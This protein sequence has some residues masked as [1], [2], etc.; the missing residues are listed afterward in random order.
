ME[1]REFGVRLTQYRKRVRLSTADLA[2]HAGVDYMQIARYEKG[3][4]APSLDSAIRLAIV[5][6]VSLDELVRGT[7]PP[8]PLVFKNQK[9]FE[10][11]RQLDE[12]PADRQEMALRVLETVIA[13]YHLEDL[14]NRLRRK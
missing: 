9:L 10:C 3:A 1:L 5:L 7:E 11:M 2:R 6:D 8:K 14:S 4:T 13:G 12:I